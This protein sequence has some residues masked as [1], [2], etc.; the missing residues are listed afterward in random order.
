MAVTDLLK[1]SNFVIQTRDSRK[2]EFFCIEA[3]IPGMSI[4]QLDIGFNA[5]KDKRPGDSIEFEPLT[6]TV[7]LDENLTSYKN[8]HDYLN[9]THDP[10]TNKLVVDQEVFDATLFITSN[11]NNPKFKFTFRDAWFQSISEIQLQSTSTD[12]NNL[13]FTI[14]IVYNFFTFEK[15]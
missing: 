15:L 14:G 12:E 13:S 9:L 3:Q 6:L 10:I 1:V 4:G 11:K 5:M 2:I 7:L 8:V